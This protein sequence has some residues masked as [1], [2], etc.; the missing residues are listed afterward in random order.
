MKSKKLISTVA[1]V[2]SMITTLAGEAW[3]D[4]L[5]ACVRTLGILE[6]WHEG[7]GEEFFGQSPERPLMTPYN[8]LHALTGVNGEQLRTLVLGPKEYNAEIERWARSQGYIAISIRNPTPNDAADPM[9][10]DFILTSSWIRW[11]M[12]TPESVEAW[13]ESL[14]PKTRRENMRG[15]LKQSANGKVTWSFDALSIAEYEMWRKDL[16]LPFTDGKNGGAVVWRD[17]ARQFK[18]E[19]DPQLGVDQKLAD[20]ARIF[21]YLPEDKEQK[22]PIGG[23]IIWF[24][25]RDHSVTVGAAAF[26]KEARKFALSVRGVAILIEEAA[27]RNL[28]VR[29]QNED[30]LA[31]SPSSILAPEPIQYVSYGH[32][33]GIYGL[34]FATSLLTFKG[35]LGMGVFSSIAMPGFQLVKFL[36]PTFRVIGGDDPNYQ[37]VVVTGIPHFVEGLGT[38]S[39]ILTALMEQRNPRAFRDDGRPRIPYE[40]L[41]AES[42]GTPEAPGYMVAFWLGPRSEVEKLRLPLGLRVEDLRK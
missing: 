15:A 27:Q 14:G 10:D 1:F 42:I 38:R 2:A 6:D 26:K 24:N 22:N 21:Y 19:Y 4:D 40:Q 36:D 5:S 37:G 12:Q 32:D 8:R 30:R 18:G 3:G 11:K 23:Q 13:I 16:F 39:E 9:F 17:A 33:N 35:S 20:Y 41:M 29:Q 34:S 28:Q 7:A 31:R 25:R